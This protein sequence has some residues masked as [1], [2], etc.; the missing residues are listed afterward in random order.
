MLKSRPILN[1]FAKCARSTW[2]KNWPEIHAASRKGLPD[3][4]LH[5]RP[6][7]IGNNVPVFCYHTVSDAGLEEDL[8]YLI[9][10]G[11]KT[12]DADTL[13]EHLKCNK[14]NIDQAVVLT[15]DDGAHN[16]FESVFPLLKQY[17]MKGIA[18]IA[19]GFHVENFISQKNQPCE[20]NHRPL[21]WTE[22]LEISAS[23]C[24]DFQ[25]HTH[26]HRFVPRWPEPLELE[27]SDP[28]IIDSL[29]GQALSL[30]DDFRRAKEVLE[31][32]I[33][34][35]I[36]HL[37]FPKF[38]GTD[39]GVAVAKKVG[40]EACWWGVLPM[41]SGNRPNQSAWQIV[42]VDA[43][44]LRRLPGNG[45]ISLADVMCKRYRGSFERITLQLVG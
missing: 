22:I 25:S 14:S 12:I 42:R 32:K 29:R 19:P 38:V 3:F 44:Y 9:R 18:F 35:R 27:G 23:G 1:K 7:T 39:E 8:R 24:I 28:E 5:P 36:R 20:N 4:I 45:R 31:Q 33:G 41:R 43:R 11:Y 13:L 37:A 34:K 16:L 2:E 21:T 17:N 10:N 30:E 15:F 6:N 40:Y 26:Q